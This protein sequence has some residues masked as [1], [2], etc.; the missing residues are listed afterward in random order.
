LASAAIAAA[1]RPRENQRRGNVIGTKRLS[2]TGAVDPVVGVVRAKASSRS[3][4]ISASI[5]V[6][7]LFAL[8]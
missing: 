3:K 7:L 4:K 6:P 1:Q 5:I 2:L 8:V